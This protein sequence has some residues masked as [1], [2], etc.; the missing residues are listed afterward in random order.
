MILFKYQTI[1]SFFW[2]NFIKSSIWFQTPVNFDDDFDSNLPLD[3]EYSEDEIQQWMMASYIANFKTH[4][5]FERSMR[6]SIDALNNDSVFKNKFFHGLFYEHARDRMGISCFSKDELNRVLWGNYTNKG[7]GVCFSFDTNK[8]SDF[9]ESLTPV[10][11]VYELPKL[12]MNVIN[13]DKTLKKNFTYKH[14]DWSNQKELRLFRHNIGLFK[15]NPAS[16]KEIIFGTRT[17]TKDMKEIIS[18]GLQL[19]Q[20]LEFY[21]LEVAN[22]LYKKNKI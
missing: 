21:Q 17:D 9:F 11:Y 19:N 12:K 1:D 6:K 3:V 10:E 15:F 16:L 8:D 22:G 5:G 14:I 18:I 7:S 2:N 13:L 4:I 20:D